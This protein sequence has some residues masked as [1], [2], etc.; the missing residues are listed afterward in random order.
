[1]YFIMY[2]KKGNLQLD[3]CLVSI[4]FLYQHFLLHLQR[5]GNRAVESQQDRFTF[6]SRE[7]TVKV[8]PH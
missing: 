8:K 5:N 3:S 6:I 4:L 2:L 7:Q 1:M